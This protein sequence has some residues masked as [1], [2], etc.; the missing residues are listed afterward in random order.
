MIIG[1]DPGIHGALALYG[2]GVFTITDMPTWEM[3]VSAKKKRTR[4]DAIALRDYFELAKIAGA[5]LAVIEAVGG[6]PKQSA[7]H[8]FTFGYTV[9]LVYMACVCAR[10][11]VETVPASVWKKIMKVPGKKDLTNPDNVTKKTADLL[12]QAIAQRA[13]EIMPE[14]GHMWRGPNGGLK[15]DRA[16]AAM[17]AV[18]AS[19]YLWNDTNTVSLDMEAAERRLAYRNADT[20]A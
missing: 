12:K 10:I 5:E 9:G 19:R 4:V 7:Q 17:I 13:D 3:Q 8:A 6:R 11:P 18:Y 1:I 20:G 15:L 16:E 14:Y 2:N